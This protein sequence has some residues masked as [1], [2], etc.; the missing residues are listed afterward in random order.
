MVFLL[1]LVLTSVVA[2]SLW[3]LESKSWEQRSLV[4]TRHLSISVLEWLKTS[5]APLSA[6]AG[7]LEN[8]DRV[9]KAQ[10]L[11][12]Q[13][14]MESRANVAFLSESALMRR[15]TGGW[16]LVYGADHADDTV[17]LS[18]AGGLAQKQLW[19]AL[20]AAAERPN[21]WTMS[22]PIVTA[23]GDTAVLISL[24][25]ARD[26]DLVV[27]GVLDTNKV[28]GNLLD[29]RAIPG[30]FLNVRTDPLDER[31]IT[32]FESQP[33]EPVVLVSSSSG[34]VGGVRVNMQWS[35]TQ[36]FS[37]GRNWLAVLE[38]SISGVVLS[39]LAA[40]A[41][42]RQMQQTQKIKAE[43]ERATGTLERERAH[44]QKMFDVAPIGI[45]RVMDGI[46]QFAN[47]RIVEL[48]GFEV[49]AHA[50]TAYVD[51][52]VR[53]QLMEQ[54]KHSDVLR[55]VPVQVNGRHGGILDVM[56]TL[57]K[58]DYQGKDA[59]WGWA[60]DVTSLKLAQRRMAEALQ[61]AESATRAKSEFLANMS[62]EIRTPMNAIIGL[63]HLMKG[64]GLTAD[65]RN[66]LEK[67]YS[68]AEHLLGIING[69]LDFSKI[70]ANMLDIETED[71]MLTKVLDNLS[72]LVANKAQA[73]GLELLFDIAPEVPDM[74]R[75]DALRVGQ[76][77]IN[78]VNNAVKF[79]ESGEVC[80]RVRVLERNADT[81]MLHFAVS[82]TG[83]GIDASQIGR[84]FQVFVQA[85][86]STTRKYGGT[87]LGLAIAK[88]LA[89]L[90][91][92]SVGAESQIGKG[93]T[94]WFTARL[95]LVVA[96]AERR[97]PID[98]RGCRAL[99]VDDH[100]HARELLAVQLR[101][102]HFE[103]QTADCGPTAVQAVLQAQQA[104]TPFD[105]VALDWQMPDW[106]GTETA[107]RIAALGLRKVP[108]L[109]MV[110]AFGRE[111][112]RQEASAAHISEVLVKPVTPSVVFDSVARLLGR[113]VPAAT[114]P[115]VSQ[116]NSASV[117]LAGLR[118]LLV[119]DND[120]NQ[121]VASEL[122]D[123]VGVQFEIA[124]NGLIGVEKVR[125]ASVPWDLVLMDMQMPVM[126]GISATQELRK[127]LPP[128]TLPI[129]AM[130]ANAMQRDRDQCL[131]AGM[132]DFVSK[133]VDPVEL[134]RVMRT[135]AKARPMRQSDKPS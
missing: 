98:F 39:L 47:P 30:L 100:E 134:F 75:G 69:I 37:G 21:E 79:T 87:G 81:V 12:M 103:V 117:D 60:V 24:T 51:P 123:S 118:V 26:S 72:S 132:Q 92:G 88:S 105:L 2:N 52:A 40:W 102:M 89:E 73:K 1:G 106:T 130:T 17:L 53:T 133:P 104:E 90:M 80:L 18:V 109:L 49:G 38:M 34:S 6:L 14:D 33:T 113:Y 48:M 94:F 82:D 97:S 55:D 7:L 36:A 61:R 63:S 32:L 66:Y 57:M 110:T 74:L 5:Y 84:L 20:D 65:Q 120:L 22:D 122:L 41:L 10:F 131:A 19:R 86:S 67:I 128:E 44:L 16:A 25:L 9:S 64:S 11:N 45:A 59:L 50:D 8:S 91:H 95:G 4:E 3:Q 46:V 114:P 127:I 28:I 129:I 29:E 126:D 62:H 23:H 107:R 27:V 70:E 101:S 112:V 13:E 108:T 115:L 31:P 76:I 124:D 15:Q 96:S 54:I 42:W 71:F 135:W 85:D 121:L 77:L 58:I 125:S 83:I 56:L 43:V 93:A 68:S 119:E 116:V 35:V 111:E 78:F 99:V